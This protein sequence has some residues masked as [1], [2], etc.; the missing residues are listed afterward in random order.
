MPDQRHSADPADLA[1][2]AD[3]AGIFRDFAARRCGSYA[4]LY[5][6]L[7]TGIA[8]DPAL[9]AIAAGAAPGQSP[10]DLVLA[11]VHYLL[12]SEPVHPLAGYYPTLTPEPAAG[13]PFPVFREFCLERHGQLAALVSTRQVQT[14]EAGRG[15]APE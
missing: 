15:P 13:D 2:L 14:N 11:A 3:L 8:G 7:G 6:R 1:D 12:A 5:A 9:L 10:P 4:P